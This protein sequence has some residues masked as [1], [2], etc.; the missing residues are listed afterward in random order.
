M[1]AGSEERVLLDVPFYP[2]TTGDGNQC[3]QVSMQSAMKYYLDRDVS[4]SELDRR[5][6]K[7]EG[8]G[9]WTPQIVPT[10]YNSGLNVRYYSKTD[11]KPYLEGE[12]FIRRQYGANA[13]HI[14]EL[15][16]IGALVDSVKILMKYDLFEIKILDVE[17]MRAH[18]REKHLLL[19]LLDWNKVISRT[20]RPYQGHMGVLTGFDRDNF[21]FHNSGPANPT[22]NMQI[23]KDRLIE[24]WNANGTDNDIVV[25][26]GKR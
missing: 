13:D 26:Y 17:M 20:D 4:V 7:K 19:I 3:F 14:L 9:T 8:K 6:N 21:Y 12:P 15:T 18:L 24:A 10:L 22:P 25:V 11:L 16:D 23:P 2:N 1:K 5:T